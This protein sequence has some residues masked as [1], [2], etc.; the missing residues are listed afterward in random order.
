MCFIIVF[1]VVFGLFVGFVWLF[2]NYVD[3]DEIVI[4]EIEIGVE[5]LF[6]RIN[7]GNFI[8]YVVFVGLEDGEFVVFLYGFLEFWYM[9]YE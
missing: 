6:E 4:V 5:F 9:W 8:F 3:L 2:G 7:V 1:L